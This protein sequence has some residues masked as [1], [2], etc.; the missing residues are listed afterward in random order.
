MKQKKKKTSQQKT[1]IIINTFQIT[2]RQKKNQNKIKKKSRKT[3]QDVKSE[4]NE[5]SCTDRSENDVVSVQVKFEKTK[6]RIVGFRRRMEVVRSISDKLKI[7][8]FV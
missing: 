7:E 4:N 2:L 8:I 1:L 5:E 3:K 6:K